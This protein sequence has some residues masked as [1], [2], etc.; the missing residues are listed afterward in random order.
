MNNCR[1][2]LPASSGKIQTYSDYNNQST[3]IFPNTSLSWVKCH[4]NAFC[5]ATYRAPLE[6]PEKQESLQIVSEGRYHKKGN[7]S[8][9]KRTKV[10][11]SLSLS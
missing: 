4:K 6:T 1:G 10:R 2:R 9:G 8:T 11:P 3:Q 5:T 7:S